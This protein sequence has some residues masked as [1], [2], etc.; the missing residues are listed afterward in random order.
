MPRLAPGIARAAQRDLAM[1]TGGFLMGT[2]RHP[3][4]D[5]GTK[6]PYCGTVLESMVGRSRHV[7]MK[8]RCREQHLDELRKERRREC[9]RAYQVAG[10][11]SQPAGRANTGASPGASAGSR[12]RQTNNR[13]QRSDHGRTCADPFIEAFPIATAG[14]P[15]SPHRTQ[16]MNVSSYLASCRNLANPEYF[17]TAELLMTTGLSGKARTRHLKSTIVSLLVL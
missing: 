4:S 2:I 14:Q 7:M 16:P 6:C 1:S 8:P 11:S 13:R 3:C 15:I 17:E 10:P 12:G 5:S 9:E